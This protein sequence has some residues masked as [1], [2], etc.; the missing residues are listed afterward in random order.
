MTTDLQGSVSQGCE[1]E[2]RALTD[3]V[4]PPMRQG[5]CPAHGSEHPLQSVTVPCSGGGVASHQDDGLALGA[6]LAA[7]DPPGTSFSKLREE[8]LS[9]L[10]K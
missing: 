6:L 1:Q 3:G 7:T 10:S 2:L 4:K 8:L 5:Q 9:V